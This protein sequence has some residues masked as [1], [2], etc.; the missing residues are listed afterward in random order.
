[1]DRPILDFNPIYIHPEEEPNVEEINSV[2]EKIHS[3]LGV[4]DK[5]FIDAANNFNNLLANTK[6]KLSN[7]KELL[8]AERERKQDINIL[9][10]KFSDFSSVLNLKEEDF[11]GSLQF[12]N[13]I[14]HAYITKRTPID[15]EITAIDG[16][17][18]EGNEYVYLN[19]SFLNTVIDTS[20]RNYI[21]DKNSAT[22]YEYERITIDNNTD[23]PLAFNKDSIEAECSL[24]LSADETFNHIQITSERDD[25]IL[26]EVYVSKDGLTYELE[27]EYNIPINSRI[28]MYN[29]NTYIY[30]SGIITIEPSKYIKIVLRSNGYSDDQMAFV[31]T[32][33][34]NTNT[35]EIIK[36]IV[37]VDSGK[38]HVIKINDISILKNSYTKGSIVSKELITTPIK[39]IG[40]Y[41]NEY[42]NK[43]YSIDK[44]VNYF[45][46]VNGQEHEITPVNS[47]RAGKKIVRT[48]S[49][50]YK[51]DHVIY[52]NE[53]IKS[54]KL[55]IVINTTNKDITPYISDIKIL[56]GGA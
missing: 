1:M 23:G 51:S 16:N 39:T 45:L 24:S 14:L 6:L 55:K 53:D 32:F 50:L 25:L 20:N 52:L 9:C 17:G 47:H 42:I 10:N 29:D 33:Y 15:Y 28:E 11:S 19:D 37:K 2:M 3:A 22:A 41:C 49:Q 38:R 54:A 44:N 27:K 34:N 21:N 43:D 7:I 31:K 13:G 35:N 30:G 36:K 4:A 48:S 46:I 8:S 26:K 40:L 12:E 5:N 56:I 18:S